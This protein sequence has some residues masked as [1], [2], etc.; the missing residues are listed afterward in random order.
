MWWYMQI[1]LFLTSLQQ[2]P[3]SYILKVQG[4]NSV[5]VCV[6]AKET[7]SPPLSLYILRNIAICSFKIKINV[8]NKC[9]E[10]AT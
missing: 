1:T 6:C 2:I 8:E 9:Q 4:P 7:T 3:M 5:C 10:Q